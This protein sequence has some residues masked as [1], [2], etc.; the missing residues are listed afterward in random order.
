MVNRPPLIVNPLSLATNSGSKNRLVLDLKH[1]NPHLHTLK[2]KCED[3]DTAVLLLNPGDFLFT[4]DIKS[5]YHHIEI[6]QDHQTYLGFQ[7]GYTNG[8]PQYFVF[9]VLPFG[10]STAPL[11]FTKI[12]KPVLRHWRSSGKRVCMFLDDGLGG[13]RIQSAIL[14]SQAVKRDLI[15]FGFLLRDS[16]C[17]WD[18][19]QIQTWLGHIFNMSINQLFVTEARLQKLEQSLDNIL[20]CPQKVTARQLAA[21]AGQIVSMSRAIGP[22]VYL[23]T[24]HI[25][26]AIETRE[27]WGSILA[28][29]FKLTTELQYW[30]SNVRA[31]NGRNMFTRPQRFDTM[32]YSDASEL[33]YRGYAISAKRHWSVRDTGWKVKEERVP[34]GGNLRQC[35]T[36]Y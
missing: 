9:R 17:F 18:P 1:I 25:Y 26:F 8:K 7:W 22:K 34:P 11:V 35:I 36:C 14:V 24:R 10:L 33:G 29:N 27:N 2:F 3:V 6:F 23:Y 13:V 16:K 28:F 12:L 20:N 31:L 30:V 4:F 19:M 21:V 32:V 5:A 15:P